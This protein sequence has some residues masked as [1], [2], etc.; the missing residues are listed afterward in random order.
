MERSIKEILS[1]I[2]DS[3][4]GFQDVIPGI[5]KKVFEE[6]QPLIKKLEVKD[7]KIL[8]R[9]NNLKLLGE[10]KNK[11]Q[12]IILS[13]EYK[14]AVSSFIDSFNALGELQN[15]YFS[16][17]NKKFTPSKTLPIIKELAVESTITDLVGQGMNVNISGAIE[18]IL[19]Q[20][21]TTGGSYANFQEQL[22]S[23]ILGSDEVDGS[24]V[25]YTKQI[26]TDA[27]HQY[28]AQYHD[29]IAQ[30]LNFNWG[31]YVGSNITT[32]REFCTLLT[33]KQWVKRSDL[34]EVIKGNINGQR[35]KLSKTTGLPLGM[36]PGTNVDNF[37][38][39][40]GGYNCGHQF[41]WVPDNVVPD[42]VKRKQE[43]KGKETKTNFY[44]EVKGDIKVNA[45]PN[46]L[47]E[48]D[49]LG[50]T[51]EN[52]LNLTGGVPKNLKDITHSIMIDGN[53]II[54]DVRTKEYTIIRKIYPDEK[55]VYNS[56]MEVNSTGEGIG[57]HLFINQL[58]EAR[59][60]GYKRFDVSAA[61]SNKYNGYYTWARFGYNL[62]SSEI[63]RFK[64]LMNMNGRS[65]KDLHEL[66][67]TKEGVS[68][69]KKNGFWF[70]G[71]F[72]L[73]A[74]SINIQAFDKYLNDRG[75]I[76]SL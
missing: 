30:D 34:P 28:N 7:G 48:L 4:A 2:D 63:R 38:I 25:R 56:L 59:K 75:Y 69:W 36:I 73:K 65:E 58:I 47:K 31:R 5:Q 39:L 16:Q 1:L 10:L 50:F 43:N 76:V 60:L 17:F 22:R 9:V 21:I 13:K 14:N 23:H 57:L 32:T 6:L 19:R 54:S 42:N 62:K 61:K 41:F 46:Y 44:D 20:G 29:A 52:V 71:E 72:D 33:E 55:K 66:M 49:R 8:N 37:K 45:M 15:S 12:K 51:Y 70:E 67:S 35:C 74:N 27:I 3:I 18:E 24:M 53:A 68:F 26:T 64:D 11:L 40:R